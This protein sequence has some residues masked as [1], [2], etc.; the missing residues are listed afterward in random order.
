MVSVAF[1]CLGN[2]CR[3]PTAE[4]VFKRMVEERGLKLSFDIKSFGTSDEEEGN[5]IYPPSKKTLEAHGIFEEH[6]ARQLTLRDI[7]NAD[8]VLVMDSQNL[9][10]VLRF[11]GGKYGEKI[12]KL[13]SFTPRPRDISDPWY[14]RD[15]ERAYSEI[16]E[17][18]KAF[19]EYVINE[20]SEALKYDS[21]H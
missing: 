6:T 21:R 8:Y 11:T 3:S 18:C 9:L 5:P 10:D 1:V 14:S 12:F 13:L 2:I 15:F 19:L 16:Y 20:K 7:I 17:G 4:L